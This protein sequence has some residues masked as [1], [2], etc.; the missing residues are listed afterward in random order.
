MGFVFLHFILMFGWFVNLETLN[1][2]NKND[3]GDKF[4]P[5]YHVS[6]TVCI[7]KNAEFG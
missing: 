5:F 6:E 4:M 3:A 2:Y 1:C 7:S